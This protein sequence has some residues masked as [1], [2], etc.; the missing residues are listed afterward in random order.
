M[1]YRPQI[2]SLAA[3]GTNAASMATSTGVVKYDGTRLVTSSTALIDSSNRFL[4]SSQPAFL[5]LHSVNQDNVTGNNTTVTINF[6]TEVF[7]Q[8]NNYDGTNTFTA[9]VTGRYFLCASMFLGSVTGGTT[10]SLQIVTS[11]RS[12][13]SNG[14]SYTAIQN[15]AGAITCTMSVIA[16]MDSADTAIVQTTLNGIG[17]DTADLTASTNRTYFSGYLIC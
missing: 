11:N 13:V 7:D 5:A 4:N 2:L 17:A 3:G 1:A 9:P 6:T 12:Y 14:F 16:D 10:G 15:A 8:A